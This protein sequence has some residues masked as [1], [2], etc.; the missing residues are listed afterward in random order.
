[1]SVIW[2]DKYL[3]KKYNHSIHI[4]KI[5]IPLIIKE[6]QIKAPRLK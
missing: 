6:I 1:M 5:L 4:L 2:K 3:K